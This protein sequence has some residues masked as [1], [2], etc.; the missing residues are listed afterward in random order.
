MFWR[1]IYEIIKIVARK[2]CKI[3]NLTDFI[4]YW[5]LKLN[6]K[7]KNSKLIL[8]WDPKQKNQAA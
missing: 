1:K 3:E 7:L 6:S 2:L 5:A 4:S 8:I